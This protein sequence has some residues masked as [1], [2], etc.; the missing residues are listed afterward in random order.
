MGINVSEVTKVRDGRE[1]KF[2]IRKEIT[3][4]QARELQVDLNY[5]PYGY[6]FFDFRV[7]DGVSTWK[8]YDNCD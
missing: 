3:E 6:S 8:C 7:K 2:V 5:H 4:Q 1:F